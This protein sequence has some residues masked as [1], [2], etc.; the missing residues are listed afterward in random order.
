[1]EYDIEAD[2]G[3]GAESNED[4]CLSA[5]SDSQWEYA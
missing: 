1:M 5:L 4:L 3:R 2:D